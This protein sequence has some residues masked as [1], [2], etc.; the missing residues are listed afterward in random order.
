LTVDPQL[1]WLADAQLDSIL[2]HPMTR[3][4]SAPAVRN[5]ES[6]SQLNTARWSTGDL[7]DL[8]ASRQLRPVEAALLDRYRTSLDGRVLELG[9]GAGRLTGHLSEISPNVHGIDLSPAM[10]AYCQQT[11]PRA[12]F[13]VGDLRDLSGFQTGGYDAVVAPFNVLDVLGDA[14]R[15]QVLSDI[16]R[17]MAADGV[18]IMSSHNR[19]YALH[20][21][22]RVRLGIRLWVGSPRRPLTSLRNL[23][24]RFA[25]RRRLGRLQRVE[26]GYAIVNDEAHDFSV[27]HYYISRDAQE[28]QLADL[29]YTLTECLDLHAEEVQ[30]GESATH[31]S[32]LHYVARR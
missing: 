2:R 27:L 31:C 32:E 4:T 14:E 26:D 25:N 6:Q 23:P 17:L 12:S 11:Y 10:V 3:K 30:R 18:L 16:G 29:G 19:H 8:Y 21:L 20:P 15:R 5:D 22:T 13:A 1:R 7:V 28:S 9:C 24:L